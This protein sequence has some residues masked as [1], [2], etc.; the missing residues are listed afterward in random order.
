[1]DAAFRYIAANHGIDTEASYPYEAHNDRCRYSPSNVG[2]T[3]T[4]YRDI[5]RGDENAL[6]S[7]VSSVGP[8]AVAIDASK[9]SFQMYH[10]GVYNEYMCSSTRLDHGV[11]A[12]GYG[13]YEGRDYWLV[14]NSWG[15]DWGME[16]YI[17]MSRNRQNQCGIATQASYPT[18]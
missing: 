5:P 2:A 9:R 18:V 3:D 16:G 17:M 14:K 13:T 4:G 6:R 10:S 11:L 8:I 7:A 15:L 12:V 1:M